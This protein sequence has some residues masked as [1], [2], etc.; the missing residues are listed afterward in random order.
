MM[1]ELVDYA[2]A[3]GVKTWVWKAYPDRKGIV[4][5]K[6]EKQRKIFFQKCKDLGIAGLKVDFFDSEAQEIIQFYQ[7][8]LHDAARI[9]VND[10]F[11][12]CQQTN[13]RIKNLA[14]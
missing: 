8:A 13:R 4:G 1:K 6:D 10:G 14:Q 7:A 12:W 11:S 2:N 9:S 3:K 5:I